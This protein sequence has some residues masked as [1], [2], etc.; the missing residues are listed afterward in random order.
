MGSGDQHRRL[1]Q[2]VPLLPTDCRQPHPVGGYDAIYHYG[3]GRTRSS[4][5]AGDLRDCSPRTSSR[6]IPAVRHVRFT[7]PGAGHRLSTRF[8]ASFGSVYRGRVAFA[9]GLHRSRRHRHPI[10][11]RGDVRPDWPA[12]LTPPDRTG[13]GSRPGHPLPPG[14]RALPRRAGR[15]DGPCAREDATGNGTCGCDF[16]TDWAGIRLLTQP[17]ELA[18]ATSGGAAGLRPQGSES[19]AAG[20]SAHSVPLVS[21]W[22]LAG[23]RGRKAKPGETLQEI[24]H[25]MP[26]RASD[27]HNASL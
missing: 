19:F 12:R 15:H 20:D 7:H 6:P 24:S 26:K 13:D 27:L 25:A 4:R 16:S 23:A 3:R 2:P 10:R 17:W 8:C 9:D 21:G 1:G 22:W 18:V 14:N 11:R 5:P